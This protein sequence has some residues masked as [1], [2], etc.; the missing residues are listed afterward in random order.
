MLVSEWLNYFL[1]LSAEQQTLLPLCNAVYYFFFGLLMIFVIFP[2]SAGLLRMA[3]QAEMGIDTTAKELFFAFTNRQ[4][5][6]KMQAVGCEVGL[7][8]V[9]L[10]LIPTILTELLSG[11]AGNSFLRRALSVLLAIAVDFGV[12]ALFLGRFGRISERFEGTEHRSYRSA[13]A[14]Y[15]GK[16]FPHLLL[17][18]I[19][20]FIYFLADILPRMLILYFRLCREYQ[21]SED[22]HI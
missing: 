7:P 4:N 15:F 19:T 14:W 10:V 11:F 13:G 9:A 17:S 8:I 6:K 5:Y 20:L 16:L 2:M 1:S 12:F 3:R 22:Y 18:V 21:Q